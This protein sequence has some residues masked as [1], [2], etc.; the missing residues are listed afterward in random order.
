MHRPLLVALKIRRRGRPRRGRARTTGPFRPLWSN[1]R[2]EQTVTEVKYRKAPNEMK[3]SGERK[4]V[5]CSAP[6]GCDGRKT[7]EG[8][9]VAWWRL[10]VSVWR[11]GERFPLEETSVAGHW[12]EG[13]ALHPPPRGCDTNLLRTTDKS[14]L[15]VE[16][17][18]PAMAPGTLPSATS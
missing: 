1:L 6:L 7:R 8:G 15:S 10:P 18:E 13:D 14:N 2:L 9:P 3:L 16:R 11:R 17:N 12:S 4:R 5:R